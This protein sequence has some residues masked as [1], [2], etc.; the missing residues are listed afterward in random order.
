MDS[1]RFDLNLLVTL[2]ALLAEQNVTRAAARLNLSQP[3][4]S[5]QLN[6]LR[7]L[8]GDQ[9][10]VPTQRG[11]IPTPK[12]EEL[13]EPIRHALE[14]A[15][16]TVTSHRSFEPATADLTVAI[17]CTDYLQSAVAAPLIAGLR[18]KA[19]GMRIALRSLDIAGLEKEMAQGAVDLALMTPDDAP[20]NLRT[21]HLF[22]ERYVLVGR[23]GHP[24]LPPGL[25]VSDYAELD[26]V[27]VA[28]RGRDFSTPVDAAV[29]ALG[30]R[31]KVVVSANSFLSLIDIVS[32]TELVALVPSR[33]VVGRA[34]KLIVIEPPFP[35]EGFA[36]GMVW[37]ERTQDHV[38]QR[39]LREAIAE[40]SRA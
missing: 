5:A 33:L 20:A 17:A 27:V 30:H 2:E 4:V 40:V 12:S 8:F 3:A 10:F 36:V 6:R 31:R 14:L 21:R 15:R 13:R 11:M 1:S 29:K 26:H 22:D 9:L 16:A 28:L 25:T 24:H 39:W 38:G 35:V 34:E 7:D 32:T 19:P 37:H 23:A 18:E